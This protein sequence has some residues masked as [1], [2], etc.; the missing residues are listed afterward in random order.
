VGKVAIIRSKNIL[1][2]KNRLLE[3]VGKVAI[4]RSKNLTKEEPFTEGLTDG[5][6]WGRLPLLDIF[7]KKRRKKIKIGIPKDS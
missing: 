1:Q 4:I 2:K 3:D 5:R 6:M 7:T